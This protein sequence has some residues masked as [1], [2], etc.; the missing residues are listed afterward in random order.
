[1][2]IQWN[3]LQKKLKKELDS[4]RYEHTLGVMYT[5]SCLAMAY[6]T[7]IS[8]AR[9]AGLLH[10]CAKC[11]PNPKKLTICKKAGLSVSTFEKEYPFLLH[12]RLGAYLAKKEY[13]VQDP[14]ILEAITWHT[15]GKA[16]MSVLDKII[17]IAD[18]IEPNRNKAPHLEKLRKL[19]FED[20]DRCMY[21]ILEDSVNYLRTNPKSMDKTTLDAYDYY[22]NLCEEKSRREE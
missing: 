21:A 13:G 20:L 8:K 18:Y 9:L 7:D 14:E 15:T 3:K 11:I 16:E 12:A 6:G 4:N 2:E 17:Y 5:A 22:K 10:D 19:A 1:M